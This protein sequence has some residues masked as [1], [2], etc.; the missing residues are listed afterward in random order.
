MVR[1]KN[2]KFKPSDLFYTGCLIWFMPNTNL[3]DKVLL[4]SK[5]VS[6]GATRSGLITDLQNLIS[7]Y[8]GCDSFVLTV[9]IV[10]SMKLSM[11]KKLKFKKVYHP[12]ERFS[13]QCEI[14]FKIF[15]RVICAVLYHWYHTPAV[16]IE[17]HYIFPFSDGMV[18]R[19]HQKITN[20]AYQRRGKTH[21]APLSGWKQISQTHISLFMVSSLVHRRSIWKSTVN[22]MLKFKKTTIL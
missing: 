12:T 20:H 21:I 8:P 2:P 14:E 16:C 5:F 10:R 4:F 1:G 17:V 11:R 19:L 13:N 9:S 6:P 7:L 22:H 18:F 3:N 15:L